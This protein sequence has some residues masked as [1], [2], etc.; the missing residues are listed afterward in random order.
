[1]ANNVVGTLSAMFNLAETW[2]MVPEGSNPYPQVAKHKARRRERFLTEAEFSRLGRV[3][4]K[5]EAHG[6]V[7]TH[8]T[9]ALRLLMLTGALSD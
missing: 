6:E 4:S 8:A 3:L 7:S 9:A 5:T 1:M 2:G